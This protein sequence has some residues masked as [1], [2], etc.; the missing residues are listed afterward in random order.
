MSENQDL[1]EAA[2]ADETLAAAKPE[3]AGKGSD[4]KQDEGKDSKSSKSGSNKGRHADVHLAEDKEQLNKLIKTTRK[5]SDG[6]VIMVPVDF[7]APSREALL[8]A[9]DLAQMTSATLMVLHVVHDPGEMPGYYST[10]VKKKRV[11]RIQDI[12]KEVFDDFMHDLIKENAKVKTLKHAEN[13]MVIGLPV[14]RILQVAEKVEP[15]LVVMG[16]QGRT[17]LKH[18]FLGSK[19]EQIVQLCPVPVTIVKQKK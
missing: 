7:S 17:G 15:F 18:L 5:R 1:P 4:K 9:A 13:V 6:R 3:Q 11:D 14:T 2:A 16:S 10:L 19:A 12:A 8:F